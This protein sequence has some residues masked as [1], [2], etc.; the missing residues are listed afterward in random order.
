MA[1]A[2]AD[3]AAATGVAAPVPGVAASVD[4]H[5]GAVT[6]LRDLRLPVQCHNPLTEAA[7]VAFAPGPGR[8]PHNPLQAAMEAA[9]GNTDQS[10]EA[11]VNAVRA[12]KLLMAVRNCAVQLVAVDR[13]PVRGGG[14]GG[15]AAG[16][17]SDDTGAAVRAVEGGGSG[18][19]HPKDDPGLTTVTVWVP[20]IQSESPSNVLVELA[21]NGDYS[22]PATAHINY[23]DDSGLVAVEASGGHELKDV[24][25]SM[26][27]EGLYAGEDESEWWTE[28]RA[29]YN[30]VVTRFAEVVTRGLAK[31]T[32]VTSVI[33]RMC[34]ARRAV[35]E[36]GRESDDNI[37]WQEDADLSSPTVREAIELA[38]KM[39]VAPVRS[40]AKRTDPE[41]ESSEWCPPHAL[42]LDAFERLVRALAAQPGMPTLVGDVYAEGFVEITFSRDTQTTFPG[43]SLLAEGGYLRFGYAWF[44]DGSCFDIR[45]DASL[46]VA[47]I[48]TCCRADA[49]VVLPH[50]WRDESFDNVDGTRAHDPSLAAGATGHAAP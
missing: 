2:S 14:P 43:Q 41:D 13:E 8:V 17:G 5:H 1:A 16:A 24:P 36:G 49:Q 37:V 18:T 22:W 47:A 20:H 45:E 39:T 34:A 9:Y 26:W 42:T 33:D 30:D 28:P 29:P 40:M 11:L 10:P 23:D 32:G 15:S 21:G 25:T 38:V 46:V 50:A 27:T 35:A 19:A 44:G 3:G 6:T 48:A 4:E 31:Q 12:I 7:G